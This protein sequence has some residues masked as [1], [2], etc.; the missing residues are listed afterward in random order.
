M[1]H[2]VFR[3]EFCNR[4]FGAL[5]QFVLGRYHKRKMVLI[6]D[7][8]EQAL[9][10]RVISKDAQL[11]FAVHQFRRNFARKAA[12]D[13]HFDARVFAPVGFDMVEQIQGRR[14]IRANRQPAGG[15]VAKFRQ[16]VFQV[17]LQGFEAPGVFEDDLAGVGQKQ[18][19]GR[20][21]DQLFA[22]VCFQTLDR[23]RDS[24]LGSQ[25]LF[26]RTGKTLL[27]GH[28]LEHAQRV[29]VHN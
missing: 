3:A 11:Q 5:S 13:L 10:I 25:Q 15:F 1:R 7:A 17:A 12:A 18:V 19:F 29:Q 28:R 2:E 6:N 16:R 21:V 22:Q 4:H 27:G 9:I 24:G 14:L 8:R 26:G 23:Q 20:A